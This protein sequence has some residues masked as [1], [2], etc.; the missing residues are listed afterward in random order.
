MVTRLQAVVF[1]LFLTSTALL[2][3]TAVHAQAASASKPA[4]KAAAEPQAAPTLD[5][6]FV[7][8]L[9]AHLK[10]LAQL[11]LFSGGVLV[12]QGDTVVF[13]KGYGLANREHRVP[14]A[15]V[16]RFRIASITKQFT[17]VAV[18]LLQERKLLSLNDPVRKHLPQWPS[19]W[20]A[21]TVRQLL[22]HTSGIP[23]YT[24]FVDL[25]TF[26]KSYQSPQSM[27]ALSAEKAVNFKPGER[28]AYNN[29]AYIAAGLLI[30][31]ISGKSYADF[32]E[33]EL[34][35]PLRMLDSGYAFNDRVIPN[36]AQGYSVDGGQVVNAQHLDMSVPYAGGSLFASAA[37]LH[38]WNQWLYSDKAATDTPPRL[39]AEAKRA[40]VDGG[41]HRY[42]LGVG[43]A[44]SPYGPIYGHT[45]GMPGVNTIL[46][47]VAKPGL[48]IAV[49]ANTDATGS[50]VI[51]E[52]I[53][54]LAHE[55]SLKLAHQ[56]TQLAEA[57]ATPAATA[58]AKP[59]LGR[60]GKSDG[61]AGQLTLI[62]G[63]LHFVP[64]GNAP[65]RLLTLGSGRFL[66]PLSMNEFV[67]S[68]ASGGGTLLTTTFRGQTIE[69]PK[70]PGARY[71]G[72]AILLRGSM[73][74]W[75]AST[76]LKEVSPGLFRTTVAL[77]PGAHGF[78]LATE[79]W[80]TVDLGAPSQSRDTV[81]LGKP[82]PA[83]LRG[84]NVRLWLDEAG[85]YEFVLDAREADA[86]TITVSRSKS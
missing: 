37:D 7:A 22:D 13:N 26:G 51:S 36:L 9:D 52:T 16:T 66:E 69:L 10:T 40:V 45:G 47:Y 43:V 57:K 18:L 60:Y 20:S 34:M 24:D 12:A 17:A 65:M 23:S 6:N 39:A 35:Q 84:V 14:N 54:R 8:Q 72:R 50:D 38:R 68:R 32:V 73:N 77:K 79:D 48:T 71:E 62:E 4:S 70:Q 11:G 21:V 15:D 86:P 76:K 49:L 82:M 81:A 53:I 64:D 58:D 44:E 74:G 31:R 2:A 5:A 67:L 27:L 75:D 1:A 33:Q 3:S 85:S 28:M 80:R 55:P 42:G 29:T 59:L 56:Y 46:Q 61:P 78:K 19:Q 25:R 83:T 63:E 30:E 41:K